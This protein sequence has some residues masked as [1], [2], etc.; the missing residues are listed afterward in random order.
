[1]QD[2]VVVNGVTMN[3]V[4]EADDWFWPRVKAGQWEPHTFAIMDRFLRPG[5][6]FVDVGAW[7]GPTTLYAANKCDRVEAFECDPVAL[8]ALKTNIAAN[9]QLMHRVGLHEHALGASDGFVR[10]YSQ[11]L[12]NSETSIYGRHER[13]DEIKDCGESV[14][15]GMRD[16]L[17]VFRDAGYANCDR[18]LV[19]IDVEGAEF[20]IIPRLRE[21][22][23][24][25][26]CVWY[27]SF[28]PHNLNPAELSRFV[29]AAE[30]ITALSAFENLNWY[31]PD[32]RYAEKNGLMEG[33]LSARWID[34]LIFSRTS[35]NSM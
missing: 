11:A 6:R 14:L 22:I 1:M 28:H 18:T 5:W 9:P 2:A 21:V 20:Q 30:M 24:Q 25:S 8:R 15:V 26:R 17:T 3:V 4:A 33:F 34:S 29:R 27:V 7:I 31:W 10:M 35:L 23:A 13:F 16:A 19:K 32:F 12:G